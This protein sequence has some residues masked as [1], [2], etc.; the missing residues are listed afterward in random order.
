MKNCHTV[1]TSENFGYLCVQA[2]AKEKNIL[3]GRK[4]V[5]LEKPGYCSEQTTELNGTSPVSCLE[6][7][8]C[9]YVYR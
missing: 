1:A 7:V 2:N 4:I 9:V 5:A 3:S 8:C 6:A